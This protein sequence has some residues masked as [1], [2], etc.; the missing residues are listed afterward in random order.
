MKDGAVYAQLSRPD[1]RLPI[2]QALYFPETAPS[3]WGA[4]DFDGLTL[5]FEKPDSERFPMLALAYQALRAGGRYPVAYNAA[6]EYAVSAFLDGKIKFTDISA[7]CSAALDMD[8]SGG[9][10]DLE[11]ILQA[12]QPAPNV[13][14]WRRKLPGYSLTV[15]ESGQTSLD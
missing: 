2:H 7:I 6:N 10:D 13:R 11:A 1:M 14:Q 3:P 9:E 15:K 12:G 5:T 4:L 8:W